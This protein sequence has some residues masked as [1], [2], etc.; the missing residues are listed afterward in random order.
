MA[1]RRRRT[2]KH[3]GNVLNMCCLRCEARIG[4]YVELT[5]GDNSIRIPMCGPCIDAVNKS[6]EGIDS[7]TAHK[8]LERMVERGMIER[9]TELAK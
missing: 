9:R 7:E 3:T 1:A 5:E 4:N 2:V 8:M 6:P